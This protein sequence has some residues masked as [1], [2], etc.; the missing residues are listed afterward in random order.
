MP[1]VS[2]IGEKLKRTGKD[3]TESVNRGFANG[4]GL[5]I[6]RG[7]LKGWGS[8]LALVA[9]FLT[10]LPIR[11]N[12]TNGA[13]P[14]SEA[15]RAFPLIGLGVGGVAA[16]VYM[17]AELIG[18]APLAAALAALGASALVTGALHEDGLADVADGFGGG[19]NREDKLAIMRDSRIGTYGVLA[20]VLSLG[21]RATLIAGVAAN[22]GTAAA[23]AAMVAAA[24]A[25][26]AVLPLAM[27]V[28]PPAR[29]EGLGAAAGKPADRDIFLAGIIGG[30]AVLLLLGA[31]SGFFAL[32]TVAGV[33]ILFSV[34]ARAQIG[35]Q[36]GDVLGAYQQLAEISLL[37]AAAAG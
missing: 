10:R 28:L 33:F 9:F 14:L 36:T 24:M 29:D 13:R 5:G 27:A 15:A 23:L 26:R 4:F 7:I 35:G 19:R 2:E 32:A 18:L 8:D 16:A 21:L 25:S 30:L 37:I 6:D 34:I 17:A 20:L 1:D 11:L 3:L 22:A 12:E 31:F